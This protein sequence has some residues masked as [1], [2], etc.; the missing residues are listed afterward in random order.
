MAIYDRLARFYDSAFSPF[1][2]WF[3][4]G[5]REEL[6]SYVPNTG[7]VLELGCGTGANFEFY[8]DHELAVSSE[9]SI[10]MLRRA[11]GKVRKNCLV[12]ADAQSLP[13]PD[14]CFDAVFATLVFCSIPDPLTA[15]AEVRRVLKPGGTLALL[16]HVRPPGRL[17]RVFDVLSLASV[18]LIHD[19]FNRETANLAKES[20]FEVEEVYVKAAGAV[21]LIVC[22]DPDNVPA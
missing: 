11:K 8:H 19:H 5:W 9:L 6:S 12:Q 3:L 16:E 2:R 17:G 1:E 15:F 4:R 18:A 13:F 20:G 21:N 22:S 10:E 7:T 14:N